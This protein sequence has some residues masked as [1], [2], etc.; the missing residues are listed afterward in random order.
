VK[1]LLTAIVWTATSSVALT[2]S[3][4]ETIQFSPAEGVAVQK[5]WTIEHDLKSEEMYWGEVGKLSLIPGSL[6]LTSSTSLNFVDH[7]RAISQGRVTDLRRTFAKGQRDTD[8]SFGINDNMIPQKMRQT[9]ALEKASVVFV[10]VPEEQ[11]YGRHC[12]AR[13]V[14]ESYL[15][16]LWEDTDF[17]AFLPDGAVEPGASW[18]VEASALARFLAP[19]GELRFNTE[20]K[21][22]VMTARLLS[23]GVGGDMQRL[24]DGEVSGGL[25]VTFDGTRD[26][27]GKRIAALRVNLSEFRIVYDHTAVAAQQLTKLEIASNTRYDKAEMTFSLEGWGNL[28]WDLDGGHVHSFDFEGTQRLLNRVISET[29]VSGT[30]TGRA[31]RENLLSLSGSLKIALSTRAVEPPLVPGPK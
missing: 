11:G 22:D 24:F 2:R 1:Y 9:S 18:N 20:R 12:D 30:E 7:Y 28:Y 27:D 16:G 10:W 31:T 26:E 13:E 3:D 15:P 19:V 14:D 21:D 6:L 23:T 25:S 5:N 29:S 8:S 4:A 17:R